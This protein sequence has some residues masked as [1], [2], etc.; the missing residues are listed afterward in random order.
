MSSKPFS[1]RTEPW[2][3]FD[4]QSYNIITDDFVH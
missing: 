4:K 3:S 1:V 2:A